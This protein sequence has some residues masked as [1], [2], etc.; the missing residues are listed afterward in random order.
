MTSSRVLVR[1]SADTKQV[2]N[3]TQKENLRVEQRV[4]DLLSV[5]EEGF[6]RRFVRWLI[7]EVAGR[8]RSTYLSG[9]TGRD[10]D[11]DFLEGSRNVGLQLLAEIQDVCPEL[12]LQA[13]KEHYETLQRE[14]LTK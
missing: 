5:M 3:A 14:G 4:N 7:V 11:K 13:E 12:W 9:P 2:G 10:S 1:N 8:D 6:G